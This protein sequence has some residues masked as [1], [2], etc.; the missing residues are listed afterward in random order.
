MIEKIVVTIVPFG[1]FLG[2]FMMIWV[3]GFSALDL[4]YWNTGATTESGDY[5]GFFGM[6]GAH[7]IVNLRNSLGDQV[8][9]TMKFLP[10]PQKYTGWFLFIVSIAI[11]QIVLMN[12]VIA[13]IS[14]NYGE[15]VNMRVEEAYMKK[16]NVLVELNSVFG[17]LAKRK[18]MNILI[19]RQ[20]ALSSE[21]VKTL[22][23]GSKTLKKLITMNNI[24][25]I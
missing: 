5:V 14:E 23:K 24:N 20:S 19:T 16:C 13:L 7:L 22:S 8:T 12:L 6:F 3:L 18:N 15:V 17:R 9:D 2:Y 1:L 21:S 10:D 4:I 11:D 25:T